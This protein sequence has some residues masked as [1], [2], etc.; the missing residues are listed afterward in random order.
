MNL[1]ILKGF[2]N[3]FNRKIKKYTTIEDYVGRAVDSTVVSDFNFTPGNGVMTSVTLGK[4]QIGSDQFF[5]YE[6]T[7]SAD[8][9]VC[10]TSEFIH[11]EEDED[12]EIKTIESRWFITQADRTRAGQ[13]TLAL[14]RDSIAD[15][16]EQ[17]LTNPCFVEKGYVKTNSPLIFNAEGVSLNEIKNYKGEHPEIMLKDE[18]GIPWIV[19]YIAKNYKTTYSDPDD[20]DTGTEVTVPIEGKTILDTSSALSYSDLPWAGIESGANLTNTTKIRRIPGA[21]QLIISPI[22]AVR[23]DNG[24]YN[25]GDRFDLGPARIDLKYNYDF[26][27]SDWVKG[28]SS[29]DD[30]FKTTGSKTTSTSDLKTKM[31]YLTR[32]DINITPENLAIYWDSTNGGIVDSYSRYHYGIPSASDYNKIVSDIYN[33][34]DRISVSASLAAGS[35]TTSN[36]NNIKSYLNTKKTSFEGNT[37]HS[38]VPGQSNME[39]Y[40]GGPQTFKSANTMLWYNNKIVTYDNINY[41]K[42]KVTRQNLYS[43]PIDS[44]TTTPGPGTAGSVAASATNNLNQ[45]LITDSGLG[46]SGTDITRNTSNS[47]VETRLAHWWFDIQYEKVTNELLRFTLPLPSNRNSLNDAS[48]DMLVLPYGSIDFKVPNDNNPPTADLSFKSNKEASMGMARSI[49]AA[50]GSAL[51]DMQL[52][53]YCPYREVAQQYAE[54]GYID[55]GRNTP[56]TSGAW[57]GIYK[58]SNSGDTP[59]R[60]NSRSFGLWCINSHGTFDIE[61]IMEMPEENSEEYKV[62]NACKKFR[63]VS[64]N[65]SSIFEF[66]PLKNGG[67]TRFNVDFNYRPFN[68]YIHIAP[69]FDN[70]YG[71][72]TNDNRGLILQGDFSVGYYSDKWAEYQ[73]QNANYNEIFNRQLANIDFNQNQEREKWNVNRITGWVTE[74]L[75]LGGGLQGAKAFSGLGPWGMLGG[76][77]GGTVG[78]LVGQGVG[79]EY[80]DRKWMNESMAE[81]RSYAI[82]NYNLALGNVKAQP[83][84]LAK[85]DTLTENFKFFPFIEEY[86]CTEK[87][88]E[89]FRDK[90]KYDGMTVEV[91]GTIQEYLPEGNEYEFQ[92]IK[93]RMMMLDN[94]VDDFQIAND[95]YT[96]VNKG[97]YYVP[98]VE[99]PDEGEGE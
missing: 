72:D 5:D 27:N 75:G 60:S 85:S 12:V 87:E 79:T 67:V 73:I 71:V 54:D 39:A 66:N 18:T 31:R 13:Y 61:H 59:S 91:I 69:P 29:I 6:K 22:L 62:F 2:N 28:W 19:M 70:L 41:Y 47:M 40:V 78:G 24:S 11:N 34:A 21:G 90:L 35:N 88:V 97:F 56:F 64:P 15:K 57:S 38:A 14:K 48:Y 30:I 94:I 80:F 23:C 52:L 81:E 53:P 99:L 32:K 3:Y 95:I 4:G 36:I 58:I 89:I 43:R 49:A 93:G 63:L 10:Y 46:L 16:L 84:G 17:I 9:L 74:G 86:D 7:N 44:F 33:V 42:I 65:Y 51:Y 68:S 76:G 20:P 26:N 77:I 25:V 45:Y 96:E 1:L 50:L 37:S 82:D 83:Y 8:Y 92:R 55:L 98:Y